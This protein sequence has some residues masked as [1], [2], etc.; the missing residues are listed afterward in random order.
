[1]KSLHWKFRYARHFYRR[2]AGDSWGDWKL[3]WESA[4]IAWEENGGWD[5]NPIEMAEEELSYWRD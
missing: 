4:C 1:M 5:Y 3:A 2:I